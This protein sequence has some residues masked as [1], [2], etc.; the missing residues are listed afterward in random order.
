MD[1]HLLFL[2]LDG[3]G[4]GPSHAGTNPF[5]DGPIP[6]LRRLAGGDWPTLDSGEL[7]R[8]ADGAS[9]VPAD[10]TLGMP[11]L[12]QSGTGTTTLL[13]GTNAAAI[14]GRH[15]GPYPPAEV[16]PLL[17]EANLFVH[18]ARRSG[19]EAVAFA[20][21]YPPFFF[22]RLAR[23]SA[24]RTT[25][26]QAALA[27]GVR[28][29][30]LDD[31][32][33]GRA[34]SADITSAWW[35]SASSQVP[36]VPPREAGRRLGRLAMDHTLTVFEFFRTDHLGHRPDLAAAYHLLS[37]VDDLVAGVLDVLDPD[38][39]LLVIASDHGN[40]EDLSTSDHTR[41]PVPIVLRGREHARVAA[42]I[43]TL[44]DVTPALLDWLDRP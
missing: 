6:T 36:L 27:S 42:R 21:A 4:I 13:T 31:L 41:N 37:Q 40:C 19:V 43:S 26:T 33:A 14:V 28:L 39:S 9:I 22:E 18:V 7:A 38:T 25:T 30:G 32:L 35:Q 20:N 24:R 5:V 8:Q 1:L 29:R 23:R 15:A 3:V 34:L 16:R 12:P 10:A 17:A 11:G 44:P 2:F